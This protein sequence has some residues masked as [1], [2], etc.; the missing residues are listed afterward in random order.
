[1]I[2]VAASITVGCLAA[3]GAVAAAA[4]G[5]AASW[6][7]AYRAPS[8]Y[9]IQGITAPARNDSWAFGAIYTVRG[10]LAKSFYL[11]WGGRQWRTVSIPVAQH[12]VATLIQASSPTNVWIFGYRT[13]SGDSGAA[14]VYNGHRWKIIDDPLPGSLSNGVV[15]G[16]SE[17]WISHG[18][19]PA[20]DCTTTVDH[21]NGYTWQSRAVAG[22][23]SLVG[24]GSRPWL[25]GLA[26][27][28]TARHGADIPAVYRW[29]GT[30]WRHVQAPAGATEQVTGAASPA[31]RLWLVV[32]RPA[33]GLWR[34]YERRGST[35]SSLGVLRRFPAMDAGLPGLVYD[36]RNGFWALPF[37]WTG[38]HWVNTAPGMRLNPP[39]PLWLNSFWYN[40]LAA[41]PRSSA[42]WAV[43]LAN[44]LPYTSGTQQSGIAWYGAKP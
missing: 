20:A 27:S 18:G 15:V 24:G 44:R 31:G 38:S 35:W 25:V 10:A 21:W 11:H 9:E 19:C 26:F 36:G 7:L 2:G 41:V 13:D 34:L 4:H 5:P 3:P 29:T 6:Y 8:R 33:R 17:V 32:Q 23:L 42:V 37:H 1:M 28:A 40:Y 43:V 22:Q 12:F 16:A 30:T 39:R 14:L